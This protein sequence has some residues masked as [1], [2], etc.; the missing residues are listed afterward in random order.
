[1]AGIF[2]MRDVSFSMEVG[3]WWGFAATNILEEA[4]T[5]KVMLAPGVLAVDAGI[6]AGVPAW[7]TRIFQTEGN[8]VSNEGFMAGWIG[9]GG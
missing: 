3:G 4:L 8:Q 7:M 5:S 6:L 2:L 1:L 9:S